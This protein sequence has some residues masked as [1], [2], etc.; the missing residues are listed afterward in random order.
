MHARTA[1]LT[2]TINTMMTG[3]SGRELD[4][5]GQMQV[6]HGREE[7]RAKTSSPILLAML[8]LPSRWGCV[9]V[10]S[11]DERGENHVFLGRQSAQNPRTD[12]TVQHPEV[13]SPC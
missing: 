13:H 12:C 2:L 10:I 9:S 8:R 6:E 7:A 1:H 3:P 11:I 5:E 4:C